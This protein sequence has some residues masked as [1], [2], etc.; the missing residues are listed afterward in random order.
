[1]V[2]TV[3]SSW[4]PAASIA[5]Q[6]QRSTDN[7]ATW[8]AIGTNVSSYTL[9]SADLGAQ[10]RVIVTAT[11][12][13][14]QVPI[15]STALGPVATDP[16]A[17]TAAPVLTGTT[18]RTYQLTVARGSW[19]GTGNT[20]TYQWQRSADGSTGWTTIAGATGPT[21]TL[22]RADEGDWVRALVTATNPD[23]TAT[24]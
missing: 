24:Q 23:G 1:Q 3:S 14:G 19:N 6:W 20:Y 5:Y 15:T 2:L 4:N 17:N 9:V 10:V 11:N 22:A 21:Y 12:A 16:P 8:T 13:F 7:G 18:Q